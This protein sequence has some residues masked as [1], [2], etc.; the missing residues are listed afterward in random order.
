MH[1][2]QRDAGL[3]WPLQRRPAPTPSARVGG[4][5]PGRRPGLT[6]TNP[7]TV[8]RGTATV[9]TPFAPDPRSHHAA[10]PSGAGAPG[11]LAPACQPR[12]HVLPEPRGN[13]PGL[14]HP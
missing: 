7:N 1:A 6:A 9:E 3:A 13:A 10:L 14:T 5:T 4:L 8:R 2:T 11:A 12:K